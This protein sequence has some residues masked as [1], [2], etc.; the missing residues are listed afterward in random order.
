MDAKKRAR[1]VEADLDLT[2]QDLKELVDE[3][4]ILIR[5]RSGREFPE[6][7]PGS[8][9]GSHQRGLLLLDG[10]PGHLLPGDPQ[11]PRGLGH[12]GQRPVH[13]LRKHGRGFGHGRGLYP[14]SGHGR[15]LFLRRVSDQRPGR[16]RGGRDP[17]PPAH[18]PGQEPGSGSK[19]PPGR[20]AGAL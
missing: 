14:G 3:F 17:D 1:G 18:Q 2:A 20:D 7:A 16:G 10:A 12:G 8:A 9:L 13:G 15:E 5:K 6:E 11:H 4:K 19:D